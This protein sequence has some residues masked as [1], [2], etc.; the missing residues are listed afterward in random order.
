MILSFR[1]NFLFVRARKVAGTSVEIALSTLCGPDDISPPIVPVDERLRLELG[2]HCANYSDNPTFEAA[3]RGLILST[4]P[5]R[6]IHI[7]RPP[8]RYRPHMSV[9][10][11][12]AAY[13]QPLDG[14]QL[15]C[16]ERDPFAKVIS[17]LHMSRNFADYRA[18]EPDMAASIGD[19]SEA[20]DQAL[21]GGRLDIL[22][23]IDLYGGRVPRVLRYERLVR[24]L[25]LLAGELGVVPPPL[26]HAKRGP[27][28]N[29]IDPATVFRRDQ[30]DRLNDLFAPEL[31][32]FGYSLR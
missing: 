29:A 31:A 3:Y 28:S 11:V 18:G 6:L 14:F 1:H 4:P 13:G 17:F 30:I 32:V 2:G 16:V 24:D 22:K 12:E 8:S 21:D 25:A 20:L 5:E 15:I 9:T 27:M 10:D 7:A 19:L 26:P 23:S